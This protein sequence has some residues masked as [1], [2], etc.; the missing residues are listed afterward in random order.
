MKRFWIITLTMIAFVVI[1]VGIVIDRS[2]P[3]L[4]P[5]SATISV[6]RVTQNQLTRT[7]FQI[8][9]KENV[10]HLASFFPGFGQGRSN[11]YKGAWMWTIAIT[12]SDAAGKQYELGV[13]PSHGWWSEKW[14]DWPIENVGELLALL[15][16]L[17]RAAPE[18]DRGDEN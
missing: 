14:G 17:E 7:R 9:K 3:K 12:F 16:R 6:I 10:E 8:A 11:R 5:V 13:N 4:V 2:K 15:D 1:A 18:K